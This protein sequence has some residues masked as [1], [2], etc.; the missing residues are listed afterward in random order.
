MVFATKW[1]SKQHFPQCI[2]LSLMGLWKEQMHSILSTKQNI[3]GLAEGQVGRRVV[4]P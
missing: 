2:T 4:T 1:E 3:G